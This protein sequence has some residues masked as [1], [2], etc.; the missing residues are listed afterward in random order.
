VP[1]GLVMFATVWM[2]SH[3]INVLILL[4]PWG[5]IDAALKAA[6]TALLGALTA[7]TAFH[8]WMGALLSLVIVIVAYFVAGW[9]F[10]LTTFGTIFC[11]D[12]FTLRSRRFAP[13]PDENRLFAG[14][15]LPGVP[16]RTYG[17]V[18]HDGGTVRL[19]RYRPWLILAPQE[20][21]VPAAALTVGRGLF[22]STIRTENGD[23]YFLLPPRYRGHERELVQLCGLTGGV[24]DAGLRKAWSTVRELFGGGAAHTQVT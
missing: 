11:W 10:R 19:F 1:V 16:S 18:I 3:A 6:R 20:V 24:R 9:S 7:L 17:R 15:N 12:F 5:A 8:P 13:R 2:A 21:E 14:G 22:L 23:T 4:S